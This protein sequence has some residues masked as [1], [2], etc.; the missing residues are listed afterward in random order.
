MAIVVGGW[1][2]KASENLRGT[3][4]EKRVARH[5]SDFDRI[6]TVSMR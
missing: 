2:G 5:Q 6:L 4:A 3:L 1:A